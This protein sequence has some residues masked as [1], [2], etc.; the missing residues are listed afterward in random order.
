MA[1]P[2]ERMAKYTLESLQLWLPI[3]HDQVVSILNS[4]IVMTLCFGKGTVVD[5][6]IPN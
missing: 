1:F 2:A 4:A 5:A 3:V 6:E